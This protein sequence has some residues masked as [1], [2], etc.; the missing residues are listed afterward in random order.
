MY[1][2]KFLFF[3]TIDSFYASLLF[4]T[5]EQRVNQP[6]NDRIQTQVNK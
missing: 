4:D 3:E 1:K 2:N 5:N 6:K